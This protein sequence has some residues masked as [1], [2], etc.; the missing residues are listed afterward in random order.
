MCSSSS[1]ECSLNVA[2]AIGGQVV[3]ALAAALGGHGV[4]EGRRDGRKWEVVGAASAGEMRVDPEG[5]E[6]EEE[7]KT[8]G[9][10]AAG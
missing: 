2:C 9:V 1:S 7:F 4:W 3:V 8:R 10:S 5:A 6:V